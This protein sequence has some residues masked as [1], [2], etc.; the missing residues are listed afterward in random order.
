MF[1]LVSIINLFYIL[2]FLA[3]VLMEVNQCTV[4]RNL[5]CNPHLP[6]HYYPTQYVTEISAP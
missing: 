1:Q 6:S 5:N 2:E 4:Y 3:M